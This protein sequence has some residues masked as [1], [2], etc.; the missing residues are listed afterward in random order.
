MRVSAVANE[1]S[2]PGVRADLAG[3]TLQRSSENP[4]F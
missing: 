1:V 3:D 4:T 2:E